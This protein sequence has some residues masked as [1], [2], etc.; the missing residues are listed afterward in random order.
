MNEGVQLIDHAFYFI[1]Q[2][3]KTCAINF[4]SLSIVHVY[5]ENNVLAESLSKEAIS[6]PEIKL[7]L[8]V[9]EYREVHSF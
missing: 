3:L 8:E 7:I 5:K 2:F 4:Q 9:H 6:L 1:E